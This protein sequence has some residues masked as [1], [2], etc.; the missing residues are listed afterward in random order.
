MGRAFSRVCLFVCLFVRALKGK[1]LELSA[2]ILYSS[3]S[4]GMH[5]PRDQKV[6]G[7]GHTIT[8]TV[9]VARLLVTRAATALCCCCRR[10]SACQYDCLCFLVFITS[11]VRETKYCDQRVCM[12]ACVCLSVCLFVYLSLCSHII[13]TTRPNFTKFSLRVTCGHGSVVIWR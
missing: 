11:P 8:I 12:L 3:R 4:A 2:H 9:T 10:G 7:Q 1:R 5:W 6:K 13:K